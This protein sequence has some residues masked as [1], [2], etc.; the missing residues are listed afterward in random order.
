[1]RSLCALR[2]HPSYSRLHRQQL[3]RFTRQL[4]LGAWKI[5]L[6]W[7]ESQLREI[8]IGFSFQI[9]HEWGILCFVEKGVCSAVRFSL[10]RHHHV[11]WNGVTVFRPSPSG[12]VRSARC[13]RI[14]LVLVVT[15][16]TCNRD[17]LSL[18]RW[19]SVLGLILTLSLFRQGSLI[20]VMRITSKK[21]T[22]RIGER[23][24]FIYYT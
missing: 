11:V 18:D 6:S 12:C 4:Q 19:V 23:S 21:S 5:K 1:M 24:L 2:T 7:K 22:G 14:V 20:L 9:W 15:R 13:A 17:Q 3:Y 10:K 8:S 16:A